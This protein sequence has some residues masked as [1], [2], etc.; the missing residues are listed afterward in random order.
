MFCNMR[1]RIPITYTS[2]TLIAL[3]T[4]AW[5]TRAIPNS[6][7]TYGPK[8]YQLVNFQQNE[9]QRFGPGADRILIQLYP[10][11]KLFCSDLE[12]GKIDL[13]DFTLSKELYHRYTS[14]PYNE[15]IS[16]ISYGAELNLYILDIN[17]NN[18]PFLGNPPDPEYPNPIYPNPCS[19]VGFRQAIWHIVNRSRLN[20]I[21]GPEGIFYVPLYTPV[22]PSLG[23]YCHPIY[24]NVNPYPYNHTA[25]KQLLKENG[26]T[27][28]DSDGWRNWN[29]T[30]ENVEL[31]FYIRDDDPV[32]KA[33]GEIIS[34]ELEAVGIKVKRIYANRT[35]AFKEVMVEK[36]FHLYIRGWSLGKDPDHLIIWSWPYYWHPGFCYNY[37]GCNDSDYNEASLNAVNSLTFE[38]ALQNTLAAQ[39]SFIEK[40]L[41]VP[42]WSY[43]GGMAMSRNYTGGNA[44]QVITPD[45]GENKYRGKAWTGAVNIPSI[46]IDNSWTL[47]T[48]HPNGY[49]R[50][51]GENM[52]VRWGFSTSEICKLN[53]IYAESPWDRKVLDLIYFDTLI[54]RNPNDPSRFIPWLAEKFEIGTYEHPLYGT[55]TKIRVKLRSGITWHDGTPLTAAD[56]YFSLVELYDLLY[57]S[58]WLCPWTQLILDFDFFDPYDFEI[59]LNAK[60]YW[61]AISVGEMMILPKHIWKPV[62]LEGDPTGFA[63]D[64]NLIGSGPY[65][66]AEYVEGKYILLVANT[67]GRTVQ[68]NLAGSTPIT[69]PKGYW[70]HIPITLNLTIDSNWGFRLPYQTQ[71]HMLKLKV[72]N[73]HLNLPVTVDA[74]L[75]LRFENGS[76]LE[77]VYSG[78]TLGSAGEANSTWQASENVTFLGTTTCKVTLHVKSPQEL[79]GWLNFTF[80]TWSTINVDICGS[81]LYDDLELPNYAYKNELPSPDL[82]VDIR[83]ISK[84]AVAFGSYPGH[85]R[86]N[87]FADVNKDYKIDIRDI[88][89][90]ASKFGWTT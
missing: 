41:S 13:S 40:A 22:P 3:L 31:K 88:A 33:F 67:P 8:P 56:V 25:A 62:V 51:D 12:N 14:P 75:R 38:E 45:D 57:T 42:L 52:T 60:S 86:W 11:F 30:G 32:R 64:P 77:Y 87:P 29:L 80:A 89:Q 17:N 24:K 84:I 35:E 66:F 49:E 28:T 10:D 5:A 47:L 69:S 6:T 73:L 71:P 72:A 19:I 46:G 43:A 90:T 15:S 39:E 34:D 54:K 7:Y 9:F 4:L 79:N 76:S 58:P 55:L 82:K 1:K 2:F 20:E 53:P 59:L 23:S 44:C 21:I 70:R 85:E 16:V 68:T 37:A 63:P 18:N 36:N 26:F 48:L 27:D 74:S 65:R 78:I 83:D 50:G 61:I 81:T